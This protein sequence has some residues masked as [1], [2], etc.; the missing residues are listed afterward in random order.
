MLLGAELRTPAWTRNVAGSKVACPRGVAGE[1]PAGGDPRATLSCGIRRGHGRGKDTQRG[2]PGPPGLG[3]AAMAQPTLSGMQEAL[4]AHP[5]QG[6][7]DCDAW[8]CPGTWELV[9]VVGPRNLSSAHGPVWGNHTQLRKGG[10]Q[11]Q[12]APTPARVPEK[13]PQTLD[14]RLHLQTQ[15][16]H[17]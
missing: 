12:A 2:T 5:E 6:R 11:H 4:R 16:P 14:Q 10:A 3:T 8:R 15:S 7:G 13:Q 9:A 1:V 17:F